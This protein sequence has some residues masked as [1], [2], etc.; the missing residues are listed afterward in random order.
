MGI[1]VP[2]GSMSRHRSG[3]SLPLAVYMVGISW[4]VAAWSMSARFSTV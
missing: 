3:P 1:C 4:S 2:S